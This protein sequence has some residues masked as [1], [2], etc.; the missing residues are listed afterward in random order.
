MRRPTCPP[1]P[2]LLALGL[3][4]FAAAGCDTAPAAL[5]G[6]DN[7]PPASTQTAEATKKTAPAPKTEFATPTSPAVAPGPPGSPPPGGEQT[8]QSFSPAQMQAAV[9]NFADLYRQTIATACDQV[10]V[11]AD[12]D[13]DLRRRAQDTKINGATAMYDIAV[14]PVPATAM[15]NAAVTVTLQAN[16]IR[17]NGEQYF[18]QF[19]PLLQQKSDF[20]QEE[21]FR[22]CA[23]VMPDEKR[24]EL[25]GLIN[26]WSEQNPDVTDFWYVRL[27]D[28]PGVGGGTLVTDF[29]KRFLPGNLLNVFNPFAKGQESVNDFQLLAERT[30][31]LTPRLMILAQWRAEAVVYDSIANTRISEAITLGDRFA[32]VAEDLPATLTQQREGL[33]NDLEE[34]RET[35]E[36]LITTTDQFTQNATALVEAADAIAQHVV[37]IQATAYANAEPPDPNKPPGRPFDITEYTA[38]LAELNEVLVDLN[39]LVVNTDTAASPAALEARLGVV[40]GSARSLILTAAAALLIVGLL[41]IL[42]AKLIPR[43]QPTKH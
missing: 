29:M 21:I 3:Y 28:L 41:L 36:S 25:L 33:F 24:V 26:Q 19:A 22:I 23:R 43:R 40:E 27:T 13:P 11:Q 4:F 35:L 32:T 5:P 42:A 14:D 12:N 38:A 39:T 37:T 6:V 20:L 18:G 9:R 34:N 7:P 31:W 30:A 1:A 2:T 15:L 17:A 16:F 10:I 8:K